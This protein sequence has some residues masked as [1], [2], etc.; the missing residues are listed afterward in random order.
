M[1]KIIIIDILIIKNILINK[2][3]KQIYFNYNIFI[4]FYLNRILHEK[5]SYSNHYTNY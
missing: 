4:L 1:K 2:H 3:I 5:N